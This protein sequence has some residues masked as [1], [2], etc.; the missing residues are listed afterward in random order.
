MQPLIPCTLKLLAHAS[1]SMS[2]VKRFGLSDI[3]PK[4]HICGS[5]GDRRRQCCD[6]D[7]PASRTHQALE[8]QQ[9]AR[10]ISASAGQLY[11]TDGN[12]VVLKVC[13]RFSPWPLHL[14][15]HD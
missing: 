6:G 9:G 12:P 3:N 4:K 13:A 8:P 5:Y 15:S 7:R 2:Q 10:P 11:G 1:S 14:L